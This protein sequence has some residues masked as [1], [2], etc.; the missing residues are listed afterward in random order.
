MNSSVSI[1]NSSIPQATTI[2]ETM[3]RHYRSNTFDK[4]PQLNTPNATNQYLKLW[5]QQYN[6]RNHRQLQLNFLIS[7][8]SV[9]LMDEL[10]DVC[11]FNEILRVTIDKVN[12]LF[13]QHFIDMEPFLHQEQ[14]F[15]SIDQF[16]VDNQ[17]YSPKTSFDFPVV[18]MSKDEKR[19][20]KAKTN[21]YEYKERA[22]YVKYTYRRRILL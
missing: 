21:V 18:L 5:Q 2:S 7:K 22:K 16:Q 12:L 10:N 8:I 4:N 11:L 1:T 14:F 3:P 19:V 9:S 15:C 17:C 20:S 6:Q 13:Y